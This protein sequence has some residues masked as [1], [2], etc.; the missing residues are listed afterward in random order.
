MSQKGELNKV[1]SN[2]RILS[3]NLRLSYRRKDVGYGYGCEAD[4]RFFGKK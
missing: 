3:K 2:R 4:R 1:N